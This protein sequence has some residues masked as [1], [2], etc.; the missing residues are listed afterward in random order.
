M[1]EVRCCKEVLQAFLGGFEPLVAELVSFFFVSST[2][3]LPIEGLRY[4][5]PP[6]SCATA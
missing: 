4:S 6:C 3:L 5:F 2:N 1:Q